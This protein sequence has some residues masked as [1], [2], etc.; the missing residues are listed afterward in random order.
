MLTYCKCRCRGCLV[1]I[2]NELHTHL[3]YLY[4]CNNLPY[5][6]LSTPVCPPPS[7]NLPVC[8]T[9][10]P[11]LL[12]DQKDGDE[13]CDG[14][15]H[16][17]TALSAS[18]PAHSNTSRHPVGGRGGDRQTEPL[19]WWVVSGQARMQDPHGT[20]D[21]PDHQLIQE[22]GDTTKRISQERTTWGFSSGW[23]LS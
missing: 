8:H 13:C 23:S 10:T 2:V 5:T 22:F 1:I 17:W 7:P 14:H 19:G 9:T 3:N 12:C 6:V 21:L 11:L 16:R 20:G 18:V 4:I 15:L